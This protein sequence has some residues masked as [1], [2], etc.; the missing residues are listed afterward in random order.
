MS[1]D[2]NDVYEFGVVSSC[3]GASVFLSG[4][5]AECKDHCDTETEEEDKE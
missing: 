5:C 1:M 3:C 4:I 2:Y